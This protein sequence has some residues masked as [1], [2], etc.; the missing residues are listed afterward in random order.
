MGGNSESK[1]AVAEPQETK[2]GKESEFWFLLEVTDPSAYPAEKL[3]KWI[4]ELLGPLGGSIL[5]VQYLIDPG[6]T[7]AHVFAY[8]KDFKAAQFAWERLNN[9]E[10]A[11]RGI[12]KVT[13]M[14]EP[15]KNE[16]RASAVAEKVNKEIPDVTY[17]VEQKIVLIDSAIWAWVTLQ[18]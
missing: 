3:H 13:C 15:S 6:S 2:F 17:N 18:D 5:G 10:L 8:C 4:T 9:K 1:S 14:S 16:T 11:S 7:S 12:H